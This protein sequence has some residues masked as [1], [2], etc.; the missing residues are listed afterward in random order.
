[1]TLWQV[2]AQQKKALEEAKVMLWFV[3]FFLSIPMT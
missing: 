2:Q 3:M 1:L